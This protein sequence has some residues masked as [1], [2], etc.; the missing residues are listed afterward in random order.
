MKKNESG[1][2]LIELII[3]V[4]IIG[5]LAAIALSMYSRYL[6]TTKTTA[7]RAEL[8][9][10]KT[11]YDSALS[12]GKTQ[13]SLADLDV[14]TGSAHCFLSLTKSQ[15]GT[16]SIACNLINP[17]YSINGGVV[18]IIRSA[19]GEWTCRVNSSIG[20]TYAPNGCTVGG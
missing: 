10:L 7:A 3:A 12:A 14:P 4:A 1:F 20:N 15:D 16:V 17:P 6:A 9:W 11:N 19:T 5:I 2:S 18:S 13:P 8:E